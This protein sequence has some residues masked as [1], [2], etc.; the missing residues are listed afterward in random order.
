MANANVVTISLSGINRLT[1]LKG[2]A[3]FDNW[4]GPD[5]LINCASRI[6]DMIATA[7][8]TVYTDKNSDIVV[9]V[10]WIGNRVILMENVN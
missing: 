10:D 8:T 6:G 4:G 9:A 7:T 1:I 5:D 2:L 3:R